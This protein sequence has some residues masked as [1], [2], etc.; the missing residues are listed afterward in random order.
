MF[1]K[2]LMKTAGVNYKFFKGILTS[3]FSKYCEN[4]N[5]Y[6]GE[7]RC[8]E[9]PDAASASSLSARNFRV[10]FPESGEGTSTNHVLVRSKLPELEGVTISWWMKT[11]PYMEVTEA[12]RHI[13]SYSCN[14]DAH[15]RVGYFTL[16]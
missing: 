3:Y 16:N 4:E 5:K 7:E 1:V 12:R 15:L 11:E 14:G 13:L 9:T 6:S 2:S 8:A 10:L